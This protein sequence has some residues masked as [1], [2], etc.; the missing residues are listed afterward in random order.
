LTGSSGGRLELTIVRRLIRNLP[1]ISVLIAALGCIGANQRQSQLAAMNLDRS[2]VR[3]VPGDVGMA[4][5]NQQRFEQ[6]GDLRSIARAGSRNERGNTAVD[7]VGEQL[8]A[9]L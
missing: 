1:L 5:Q 3:V 4:G 6:I 7:R 9:V 8:R 2:G